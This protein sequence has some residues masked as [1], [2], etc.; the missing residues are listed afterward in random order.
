MGRAVTE[1]SNLPAITYVTENNIESSFASVESVFKV[2]SRHYI[3][4]VYS[5]SCPSPPCPPPPPRPT[6]CWFFSESNRNTFNSVGFLKRGTVQIQ[7][8]QL[9][10]QLARPLSGG[11]CKSFPW[12]RQFEFSSSGF[13]VEAAF[14]HW[15]QSQEA[16]R[17]RLPTGSLSF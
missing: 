15:D 5:P 7:V 10:L 14:P 6:S 13:K 2:N 4:E 1:N 16:A 3:W 11:E 12:R 9:F 17:P 8:I